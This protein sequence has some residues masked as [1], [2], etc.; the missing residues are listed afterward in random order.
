MSMFSIYMG[1]PE[2]RWYTILN[3]VIV[4]TTLF[5]VI[6]YKLFKN[7][8]N[9]WSIQDS[10]RTSILLWLCSWSFVG[11]I[12][13]LKDFRI[14]LDVGIISALWLFF[15]LLT[16]IMTSCYVIIRDSG[17]W[18]TEIFSVSVTHWVLFHN[19]IDWLVQT[20]YVLSIPI[21][22]IILIRTS[23]H[24]ENKRNG[25]FTNPITTSCEILIWVII[26]SLEL[27]FDSNLIV[28]G[29][30]YLLVALCMSTMLLFYVKPMFAFIIET[31]IIF[32]PL[33]VIWT[34][35]N[36]KKSGMIHG[37]NK[38]WKTFENWWNKEPQIKDPALKY[39]NDISDDML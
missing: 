37:L 29:T 24:L 20:P 1:L 26:L 18:T 4:Y 5:F 34:L 9:N 35:Y 21:I 19:S 16:T 3:S 36:I 28:P 33:F 25:Y 8:S 38:S 23:Y 22:C 39:S 14:V 7:M 30:Y 13:L 15:I 11:F 10:E 6:A 31:S 12:F 2:L 27:A 17:K 32:I